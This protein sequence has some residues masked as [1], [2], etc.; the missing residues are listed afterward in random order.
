MVVNRSYA[1]R[2]STAVRTF[3]E[4]QGGS[5]DGERAA[6]AWYRRH[7]ALGSLGVDVVMGEVWSRPG[8]ARRDRSLIVISVLAA[9]Q[10]L[11]ELGAH[12]IIGLQNGLRRD[13]I[14][15]LLLH[16]AAITGFPTA[17]AAARTIDSALCE[18]DHVDRQPMRE[19]AAAKDDERRRSDAANVL[20]G[21]QPAHVRT[22]ENFGD[23]G[24]LALLFEL[25]EIWARRNLSA[26]DRSLAT[27]AILTWLRSDEDLRS[28]LRAGLAHGLSL[29]E[30]VE[31]MV[32]LTVYV[33]V[34][35]AVRG[36]E[37]VQEV[38]NAMSRA[39]R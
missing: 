10:S 18:H 21:F 23:V 13:E 15:E 29:Q 17:F 37:L 30:L 14:D 32:H 31:A 34:P 12:A 39:Q 1:D 26:R 9:M 38:T 28:H 8:L 24:D 4:L 36:Y 3:E 7:G 22:G 16:V 6:R 33:G 11:K 25:G 27:I 5:V 2:H 19:P 20:A 35:R